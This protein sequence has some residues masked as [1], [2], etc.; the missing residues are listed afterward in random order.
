[1]LPLKEKSHE[2]GRGHRLDFFSQS[3]DGQPMNARQ[4]PAVAPLGRSSARQF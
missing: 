2:F 3:A 4:Q 1:M